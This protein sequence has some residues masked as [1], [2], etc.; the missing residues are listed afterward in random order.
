MA[1]P[2]DLIEFLWFKMAGTGFPNIVLHVLG[3]TRTLGGIL[4][5]KNRF[6]KN[7]LSWLFLG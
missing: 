7:S 3:S 4:G 6:V 1:P 2:A 5:P